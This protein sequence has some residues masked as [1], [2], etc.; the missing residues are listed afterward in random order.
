[1]GNAE[2]LAVLRQGAERWNAWR[3]GNSSLRLDLAGLNLAAANLGGTFLAGADLSRANL[4]GALLDGSD[5]SEADLSGANLS[6]A[7][8]SNSILTGANL[9]RANLSEA[10]LNRANLGHATLSLANLT[11]ATG[12][13]ANFGKAVLSGAGD[14]SVNSTKFCRTRPA[15]RQSP[16][17]CARS[18]RLSPI[19]TDRHRPNAASPARRGHDRPAASSAREAQWLQPA[20]CRS[21]ENS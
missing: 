7:N 18:R 21:C 15:G 11:K 4:S 16:P 14:R 8:L 5:L 1:M 3:N 10:V 20:Q 13:H 12:D 2:H 6:R 9:S 19:T 17:P